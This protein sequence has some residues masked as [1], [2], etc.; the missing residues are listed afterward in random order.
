MR[1]V[2]ESLAS[3]KVSFFFFFRDVGAKG[4]KDARNNAK[5]SHAESMDD[6]GK[7]R[8]TSAHFAKVITK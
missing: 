6:T 8:L 7:I 1:S 3:L 2:G 4:A 5:S